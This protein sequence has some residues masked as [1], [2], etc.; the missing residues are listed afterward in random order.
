MSWLWNTASLS[1]ESFWILFC[2]LSSLLVHCKNG[3]L[4]KSGALHLLCKRR[5]LLASLGAAGEEE[6]GDSAANQKT[7]YGQY[8]SEP[9]WHIFV[10]TGHAVNFCEDVRMLLERTQEE[11]DL[12]F[13]QTHFYQALLQECTNCIRINLKWVGRSRWEVLVRLLPYLSGTLDVI[14]GVCEVVV[15][16]FFTHWFQLQI[17]TEGSFAQTRR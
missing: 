3:T 9:H 13:N 2:K 10:A 5:R 14:S 12:L 6:P 17:K 15:R 8:G 7:C 1:P 11:K 16:L 4:L